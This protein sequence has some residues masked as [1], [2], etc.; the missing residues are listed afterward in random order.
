VD[1]VAG[2]RTPIAY[3]RQTHDNA[4]S[5]PPAIS[6]PGPH[7]RTVCR[8]KA[9]AAA[10]WNPAAYWARYFSI[11]QNNRQAF[12]QAQQQWL[13]AL[14]QNCPRA[15]NPQQCVLTA[16]QQRA[17]SYR[18]QLDADALAESRL[19]LDYPT[20]PELRLAGTSWLISSHSL[21]S[22]T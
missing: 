15:P 21:D 8:D 6:R 17:A 20:S 16:Y 5:W 18:S 22:A 7:S 10:D 9:G 4:R 14:N 11:A 1:D 13:E 12:D 3:P 19:R 2:L